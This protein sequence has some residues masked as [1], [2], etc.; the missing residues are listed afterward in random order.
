[1]TV[2]SHISNDALLCSLSLFV[3]DDV[4]NCHAETPS[5]VFLAALLAGCHNRRCM[6]VQAG[7]DEAK[8]QSQ[9]A[10]KAQMLQDLEAT[11]YTYLYLYLGATLLLLLLA[12]SSAFQANPLVSKWQCM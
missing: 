1:M 3:L 6:H 12:G 5:L 10:A 8:K 4:L 2:V 11:R 7:R 9:L